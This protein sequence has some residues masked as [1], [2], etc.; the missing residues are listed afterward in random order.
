MRRMPI[1][2]E[3]RAMIERRILPLLGARNVR[4]D[5]GFD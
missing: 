4:R 2:D 1:T 3:M 5:M